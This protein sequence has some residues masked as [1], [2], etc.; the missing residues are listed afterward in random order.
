[1]STKINNSG[2]LSEKQYETIRNL[3][4]VTPA[5]EDSSKIIQIPPGR[6]TPSE[7]LMTVHRSPYIAMHHTSQCIFCDDSDINRD[8]VHGNA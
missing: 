5:P 7:T 8:K 6:V 3:A 4:G 1:M 2:N